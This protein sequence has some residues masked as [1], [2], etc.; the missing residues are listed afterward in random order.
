MSNG[1][2]W[3]VRCPA[4]LSRMTSSSLLVTNPSRL[5]S[6][7]AA[8][9]VPLA[10]PPWT[11]LSMASSSVAP[12]CRRTPIRACRVGVG[13]HGDVG[14]QGAQQAFAVRPAAGHRRGSNSRRSSGC[15]GRGGRSRSRVGRLRWAQQ[16]PWQ[17]PMDSGPSWPE[18]EQRSG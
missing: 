13:Q 16:A 1:R 3:P 18:A 5:T 15:R 2:P 12:V 6:S 4:A 10:V 9:G 8:A 11:A 7:T 14:D 17:G